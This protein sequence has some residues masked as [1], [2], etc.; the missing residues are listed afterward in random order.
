MVEDDALTREM[1][2]RMLELEEWVVIEAGNGSVA[3]DR[4]KENTP[5]LVLLDL[6]TPKM[7]GFQFVDE[8][9]RNSLWQH[10]PVVVITAKELDRED[11]ERLDGRIEKVVQKS[12]YSRDE[13]M[14]Q[15]R[16]LVVS[17]LK[18]PD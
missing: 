2:Q 16:S 18:S 4:A 17:H 5:E 11:K 8:F 10:I 1:T 6:M 12:A 7:G 9:R 15:V 13:L 14:G 3:L